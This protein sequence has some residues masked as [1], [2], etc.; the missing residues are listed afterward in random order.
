MIS[1]YYEPPSEELMT[2]EFYEVN[3]PISTLLPTLPCSD[4]P[5][6]YF[7]LALRSRKMSVPTM[8]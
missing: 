6:E 8:S 2:D 7:V 4:P 5:G 3:R 1:A